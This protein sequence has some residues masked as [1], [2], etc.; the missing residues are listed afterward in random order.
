[1]NEYKKVHII[2]I[3]GIGTS[4]VAKFFLLKKAV[5]SGSDAHPSEITEELES[6]GAKVFIGHFSENITKDCDLVVYSRAVQEDNVEFVS[7]K[8][9]GI[10]IFSYAQFLGKLAEG[11]KTIAVS[12]TN[13]K[14]TTSAMLAKI[15]ID[16]GEDPTVILG[17]KS[18]DFPHGNLRMG[19][20]EWFVVEACEYMAS[21]LEIKP[22]FAIITNIEEDHLDYYRDIGHIKETF[23]KWIDSMPQGARVIINSRDL[24]SQ[25]LSIPKKS[26]FDIEE[27]EIGSGEQHFL[28]AGD[29]V[30]LKIPGEFNA[31]NAAAA[32]VTAKAIGIPAGK[33]SDSLF[34]FKGTWRRFEL[35]G[36]WQDADVF[37]DYAHHPTAVRG[38]ID[39]FKEFFHARRLIVIF[40]PHQHSRTKELFDDFVESFDSADSLIVSEIYE[41]VGRSEEKEISSS[42]LVKE[43]SKRKTINDVRFAKDYEEAESFLR[44]MVQAG[45]ILL[46]MGAG[47]ID[48]LARK[49]AM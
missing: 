19:G 4:A 30:T 26:I 27:R 3:G 8:K 9:M 14:S 48:N 24:V 44:D 10:E 39:A 16:A 37:S 13:G 12:G 35:V 6:M 23:Q 45:D 32:M 21:M 40:E 36:E 47:T 2:G 29:P 34:G 43:I 49:L 25:S 15:L 22:D 20:Q 1:M 33:A 38:T 28:V 11:Y 7:A 41:V 17:T 42:E 31:M 5:V 46:F 18:P